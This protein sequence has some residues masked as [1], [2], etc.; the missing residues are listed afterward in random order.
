M[1]APEARSQVEPGPREGLVSVIVPVRNRPQLLREAVASVFDQ[2]YSRW[3]LLIVDDG[4]TDETV[5]VARALCRAQPN[6]AALALTSGVGPGGAREAG[7][8]RARGEFLQYL[9]SDDLL[10]PRKLELQVAALGRVPEAGL[11]YGPVEVLD[12]DGR[13][14][15]DWPQLS[16]RRLDRMFPEFLRHRFWHTGAA[17]IR[18]EMSD[19]AG[20]WSDLRL[21]EDW[22][23]DCRLAALDRPLAFVEECGVTIRSTA[24]N[25]AGYGAPF[26]AW[27][28]V[29]QARAHQLIL[30]HARR[31]GIGPEEPE[32]AHFARALFLLARKCGRAGL[33]RECLRLLGLARE[34]STP[35]RARGFDFRLYRVLVG[36]FGVRA[37]TVLAERLRGRGRAHESTV[38]SAA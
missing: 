1:S 11:A 6:R 20:P 19:L 29:H 10:R 23:Y 9:D 26:E 37:G 4:S 17:L 25:R 8:L 31:A 3:E 15:R 36:A 30:G 5:E 14:R 27:R 35:R 24:P 38:G 2:T 7:R 32:M 13:P 22:E 28:L 33:R 34:A 18:R 12:L 16:E 21:F